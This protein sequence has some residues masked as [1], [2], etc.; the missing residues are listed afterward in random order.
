[1][2]QAPNHNNLV[3]TQRDWFEA[4]V[5]AGCLQ[6]KAFYERVAGVLCV[7]PQNTKKD[8]EDFSYPVDNLI[9]RLLRHYRQS[10]SGAGRP[11]HQNV[12]LLDFN[13]GVRLG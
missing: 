6:S 2:Q 9:Y 4:Q 11:D 1:M 3:D 10:S 13:I 12:A 8:F 5:L 7:D